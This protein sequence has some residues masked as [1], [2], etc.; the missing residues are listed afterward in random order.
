MR[1]NKEIKTVER[2]Q[3][4]FSFMRCDTGGQRTKTF[5]GT[6]TNEEAF[7][8]AQ[9][10]ARSYRLQY[11]NELNEKNR[12]KHYYDRYAPSH[13]DVQIVGHSQWR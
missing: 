4:C 9:A 10:Q 5:W 2:H 1:E 11:E 13:I 6:G 12:Q 7:K 8:E 3:F